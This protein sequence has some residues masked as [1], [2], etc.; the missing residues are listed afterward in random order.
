M[1]VSL[2]H[3]VSFLRNLNS[4]LSWWVLA[5]TSM[6]ISALGAV[7]RANQDSTSMRAV[8][9][10]AWVS[11]APPPSLLASLKVRC[12][13]SGTYS[14][15]VNADTCLLLSTGYFP[16]NSAGQSETQP[17]RDCSKAYLSDTKPS[18][19]RSHENATCS[20]RRLRGNE[21]CR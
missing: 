11:H 8:L 4:F 1:R 14:T 6:P 21:R 5:L 16:T 12:L 13:L 15:T 3:E 10:V 9:P 19:M 2:S 17:W 18:S 7:P 20:I